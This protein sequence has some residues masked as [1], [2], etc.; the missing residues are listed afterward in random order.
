M[1]YNDGDGERRITIQDLVDKI[2]SNE[3]LQIVENGKV[4]TLVKELELENGT[5]VHK[6]IVDLQFSDSHLDA[7][8]KE[9]IADPNSHLT[10]A[11]AALWEMSREMSLTNR[12]VKKPCCVLI[13][14]FVFLFI[15]LGTVIYFNMYELHQFNVR[16]YLVWEDP[17][18][19]D[20]DKANL[21]KQ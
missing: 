15:M 18:T 17:K 4:S 10:M 5:I 20:F 13:T 14:A 8:T 19:W 7:K 6:E 2:N 21:V 11:D 16:D 1:V 12:Y 9:L 3:N